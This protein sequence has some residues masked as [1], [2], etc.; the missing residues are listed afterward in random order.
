MYIIR[1]ETYKSCVLAQSRSLCYFSWLTWR[2]IILE[3]GMYSTQYRKVVYCITKYVG[4][5]ISCLLWGKTGL[6]AI[7]FSTMLSLCIVIQKEKL[8]ESA[9]EREIKR[10]FFQADSHFS[11]MKH[12][13]QFPFPD[14][15]A[16][17]TKV[18][19]ASEKDTML[20]AVTF[21][22]PH[23]PYLTYVHLCSKN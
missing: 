7:T 6:C 11:F 8:S 12:L 9:R 23:Q 14:E 3:S 19:I 10:V 17:L 21:L 1:L 16:L 4:K 5:A 15:H 20:C 18:G 13:H 2:S 22:F